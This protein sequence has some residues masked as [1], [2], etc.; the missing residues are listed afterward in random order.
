MATHSRQ[1][2]RDGGVGVVLMLVSIALFGLI[3]AS[4]AA[5]VVEAKEDELLIALRHINT[6]L[7]QIESLAG[8]NDLTSLD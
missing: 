7:E 8:A 1:P 6:R 2:L 5:R 4:L 3:T